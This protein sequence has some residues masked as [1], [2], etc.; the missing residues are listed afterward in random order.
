[1]LNLLRNLGRKQ[2][3]LQGLV[4]EILENVRSNRVNNNQEAVHEN[5]NIFAVHENN[6]IFKKLYN[7][8]VRTEIEM[9]DL[10]QFFG[11]KMNFNRAVIIQIF[12][13]NFKRITSHFSVH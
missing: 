5:N 2:N 10:E 3:I 4:M 11:D 1:M 7:L 9:Q 12:V 13:V 8:P 6:N